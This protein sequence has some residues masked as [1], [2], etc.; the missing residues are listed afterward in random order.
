MAEADGDDRPV[1]AIRDHTGL[2]GFLRRW[3]RS[4]FARKVGFWTRFGV[5]RPTR[6]P[7]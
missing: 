1:E 6:S 4:A 3:R 5:K 2:R 7:R